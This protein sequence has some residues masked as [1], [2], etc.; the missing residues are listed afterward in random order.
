MKK[1]RIMRTRRDASCQVFKTGVTIV[2]EQK[3]QFSVHQGGRTITFRGRVTYGNPHHICAL[4][5][6]ILLSLAAFVSSNC[7]RHA[8]VH[9][10]ALG[11]QFCSGACGTRDKLPETP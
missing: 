10:N 1:Q 7:S 3:F 9:N 6:E 8:K 5:S 4:C 11:L 2:N